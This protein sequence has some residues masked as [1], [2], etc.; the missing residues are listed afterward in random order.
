MDE[1]YSADF[2]KTENSETK[3]LPTL[4]SPGIQNPSKIHS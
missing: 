3:I 2:G 4:F 1:K